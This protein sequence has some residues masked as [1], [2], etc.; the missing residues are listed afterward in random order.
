MNTCRICGHNEVHDFAIKDRKYGKCVKCKSICTNPDSFA[1]PD[2][3]KSRYEMHENSLK[4]AGYRGFLEGFIKPVLEE[5]RKAGES[6]GKTDVLPS[7]ILD[8]GSGPEPALCE[9]MKS[10][11]EEG[12]YLPPGCDIRGW[13]PF[14][15]PAT[16]F[17]ENGADLVT[18]LEVAEHFETPLEDMKKLAAAVRSGGYAAIGTMLLTEA[19]SF[20]GWWYRSDIT[21]VAFYTRDGLIQCAESAGLSFVKAVTDRAFLFRKKD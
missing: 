4:D 2:V 9:L 18:C 5:L 8:Y 19:T 14:F 13:D 21:H 20:P 10:F 16:P 17:F 6:S 7:R 12:E 15:A 1:L 3:Q 11:S